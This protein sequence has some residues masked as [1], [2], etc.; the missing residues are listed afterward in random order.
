MKSHKSVNVYVVDTLSQRLLGLSIGLYAATDRSLDPPNNG[1][2]FTVHFFPILSILLPSY[3]FGN[4]LSA[5]SL[6]LTG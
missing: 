5:L 4:I 2:I 3:G 1:V 6:T